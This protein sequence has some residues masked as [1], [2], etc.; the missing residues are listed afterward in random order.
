MLKSVGSREVLWDFSFTSCN[1]SDKFNKCSRK[2]ITYMLVLIM[3]VQTLYMTTI[4]Q[5]VEGAS[6][7][8]LLQSLKQSLKIIQWYIAKKP[9]KE[10]IDHK[11]ITTI[12]LN[13][14]GVKNV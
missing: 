2:N 11:I 6:R 9:I 4:A 5:S 13:T 10:R 3:Y 7:I 1:F 12:I 14:K 8:I